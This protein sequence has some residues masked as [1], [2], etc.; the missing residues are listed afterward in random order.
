MT[1][2][3]CATRLQNV[4]RP[5][6]SVR[7]SASSSIQPTISTSPVSCCWTTAATSPCGVALEPGGDGGVEGGSGRGHGA[8]VAGRP[9]RSAVAAAARSVACCATQEACSRAVD[10]AGARPARRAAPRCTTRPRSTTTTSSAV[11]AVESRCAIVTDV[12]PRVSRPAPAAM[13]HLHGRV[14]G[15]GRLVEDQQVGVGEV[16]ADQ[17]DQLPL[18]RRQRLAAL[19]DPGVEPARQPVEPVG[20]PELGRARR[21]D[22]LVGWRRAGRSATLAQQRVRR[23]GSPPAAP[24][25][26]GRAARRTRTVAQ[27]DAVE[28]HRARRSGPSAGSA[29]WRSVVLPEPVSPTTATR[30]A[31]AMSRST[32]CSTGGPPG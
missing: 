22:V 7:C 9:A 1:Q 3:S 23:T 29:A 13:P 30:R 14:D 11:S 12:R 4:A 6:V 21:R 18:P 20:E 15:A 19:A 8:S 26:R 2:Y 27:V 25:P 31:G 24:A 28:Q 32:S 16:G 5:V 17:R 10:A